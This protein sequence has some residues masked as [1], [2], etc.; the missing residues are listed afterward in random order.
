MDG[1]RHS[2]RWMR[3]AFHIMS[4]VRIVMILNCCLKCKAFKI[5]FWSDVQPIR[6]FR[7]CAFFRQ[8]WTFRLPW[9]QKSNSPPP[10]VW[11]QGR[12]NWARALC[13]SYVMHALLFMHVWCSIISHL[14]KSHREKCSIVMKG[15]SRI[16]LLEKGWRK[17]T[18]K[19]VLAHEDSTV[20]IL[21]R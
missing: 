17:H 5:K 6:R 12:L 18:T 20:S 15:P 2:A 21:K 14:A 3:W 4:N 13:I 1:W 9:L 10:Y 11:N 8:L 16:W 19:E 7:F